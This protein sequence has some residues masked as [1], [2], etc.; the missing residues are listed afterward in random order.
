M[1]QT[2]IF[3]ISKSINWILPA[4]AKSFIQPL[5]PGRFRPS[6]SWRST[7]SPRPSRPAPRFPGL[8]ARSSDAIHEFEKMRLERCRSWNPMREKAWKQPTQQK[9]CENV[10]RV[11]KNSQK[12]TINYLVP[13][14]VPKYCTLLKFTR[15]RPHQCRLRHPIITVFISLAFYK[16]ST[17]RR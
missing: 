4:R 8:L 16:E 2:C 11:S 5:S 1:L 9:K 10:K 3:S 7:S 17:G 6:S 15:S 13:I 12:Q 14:S